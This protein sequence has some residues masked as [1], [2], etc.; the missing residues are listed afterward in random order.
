ML[1]TIKR[2]AA[3]FITLTTLGV[4]TLYLYTLPGLRRLPKAKERTLNGVTT[5][6][7]AVRYLRSTGKTRWALVAAAQKLVNAKMEY[8]RRNGWDTPARA[9]RRGMG[10]CQQQATALLLILQ[11]LGIEAQPVQ[12]LRC[13]FPP[14]LIHGYRDPGGV[15]GHMWLVVTLDGEERDVCPGDPTNAPGKVH[16]TVL[17]RRTRYD[18]PWCFLG[19]IGSIIL[20]VQRDN[21]ALRQLATQE[22]Q[23]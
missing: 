3:I 18:L 13:Q 17:S 2:L 22:G 5:I 21:A 20:N 1:K 4:A 10:Y 19:H 11:R 12:A 6:D 14:A 23:N 7:D 8:S 15:S 9:F 16:F